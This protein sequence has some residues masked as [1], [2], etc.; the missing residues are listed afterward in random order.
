MAKEMVDMVYVEKLY[1]ANITVYTTTKS[2][3]QQALQI[4]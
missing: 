4:Q 1:E 3:Q 2:M